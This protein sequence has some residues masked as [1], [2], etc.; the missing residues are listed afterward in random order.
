M[1]KVFTIFLI[2]CLFG[3]LFLSPWY[4]ALV[5]VCIAAIFDIWLETAPELKDDLEIRHG[6]HRVDND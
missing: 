4:W 6:A 5:V 2:T 1:I 3:A